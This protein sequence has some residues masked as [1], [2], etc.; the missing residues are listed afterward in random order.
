MIRLPRPTDQSYIAS[1][2]RQSVSSMSHFRQRHLCREQL[3]DQ[4]DRVMD[5]SDTRALVACLDS[6][7]DY[8]VG[9]MCY[10]DGPRTPTVHYLY[11]RR[12]YRGDGIAARLLER[13]GVD[14][15]RGVVC[16]SH[17]P[18]SESMRG[19]Y[20]ASVHLPLEEFLRP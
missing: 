18:S 1:T 16:T 17:G 9:W 6:D 8:I 10:V 7:T 19:R 12:D 15:A 5:R 20:R 13:I 11:L 14:R 3:N 4:I 2:W